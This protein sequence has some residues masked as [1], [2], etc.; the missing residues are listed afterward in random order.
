MTLLKIENLKKAFGDIHALRGVTLSVAKNEVYGFIG[1]NGAGKTTTLNILMSFIRK[2][3]GR[4]VFDDE[5]IGF[6]DVS[7]KKK[8]GFVPDVPAFPPYLTGREILSLTADFL[9]ITKDKTAKV[10]EALTFSGL[11]GVRQKVGNYSR[12]MRQRLSIAQALLG[13]PKLLVMDEPTSALDPVGRRE[14]LDL[15]KRLKEERTILYSTHILSDAESVA[16]RIG[17]IERGKILLESPMEK[18]RK[19]KD[20]TAYI[21]RTDLPAET[22][23]KKLEQE[24]FVKETKTEEEGLLCLLAGEGA[25]KKLFSHLSTLDLT[26]YTF[27]E[28]TPSLEDAFVEVLNENAR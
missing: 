28:K 19:A 17:L 18:I 26:V 5:E 11:K 13:D 21:I 20:L 3:A 16:D 2:D 22:L 27:I 9:G 25:E 6:L 1:H 10:D 15:I 24:P 8:I 23:A 7:Y 4:I 14:V 12:G